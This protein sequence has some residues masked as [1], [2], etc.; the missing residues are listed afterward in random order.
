MLTARG[1]P[2]LVRAT[3]PSH[4]FS[5]QAI[6][7]LSRQFLPR[8]A[9]MRGLGGSW[10]CACE[11][12]LL[13][14]RPPNTSRLQAVRVRVEAL[15]QSFSLVM[16]EAMARWVVQAENL[17]LKV[18]SELGRLNP[19]IGGVSD[20]VPLESRVVMEFTRS[21]GTR[22]W[23]FRRGTQ[24]WGGVVCEG[25]GSTRPGGWSIRWSEQ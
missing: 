23:A 15:L 21:C 13:L 2:G 24:P 25:A 10:T 6:P 9:F 3:Q 5:S 16:Q 4:V 7:V 11:A 22:P 12:L 17:P 14:Y 18:R 19:P 8:G 1:C 20:P